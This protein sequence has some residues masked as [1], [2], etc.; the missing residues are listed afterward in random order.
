MAQVE[1]WFEYSSTY[2]HLAA[3]RARAAAEAAGVR[4]AWR[5]FLL[6]PIFAAQ[7]LQDSPFNLFPAKGAN[8]WRDLERQAARH[9]LPPIRRPEVFP[10]NGLLAARCTMA[11]PEARRPAFAEA[12]F[13]AQFGEGRSISDA[14]LLAELL[15]RLGEEAGAV[16][17]A[18]GEAPA[19]AA[20][21]A[22][23]EEAQALGIFGAPSFTTEDGEL[24]WG[25]DRMEDA[26]AWATGVA[27]RP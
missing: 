13:R 2:S 5:A 8:M 24:F 19:K 1:F 16:L 21:R 22:A 12:V 6:G 25:H 3:L 15:E 17:A 26:F 11:L 18:A 14:A 20:L 7:G 23:T 4:L 10:Q 27:P 9:G